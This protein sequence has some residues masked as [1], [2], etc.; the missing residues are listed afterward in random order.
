MT[1]LCACPSRPPIRVQL[2]ARAGAAAVVQMEQATLALPPAAANAS[3]DASAASARI[4]VQLSGTP[5]QRVSVQLAVLVPTADPA[6]AGGSNR[7]YSSGPASVAGWAA[8]DPAQL[9]LEPSTLSWTAMER[10]STKHVTLRSA[11]ELP[12]AL[13][14][15]DALDAANGHPAADRPRGQPLLR[16]ALAAAQGATIARPQNATSLVLDASDADSEEADSGLPLFGF[17]ANQVAYPPSSDG[18]SGDNSSSSVARIPVRLLAGQVREPATVR[19]TVQLLS[20]QGPSQSLQQFLPTRASHGFLYFLPIDFKAAEA[21]GSRAEADGSRA[22]AAA[23]AARQQPVQQVE[24][25]WAELPLA[26]DRIPPEAEYH[27]G[28]CDGCPDVFRVCFSCSSLLGSFH[29]ILPTA[30]NV[31]MFTAPRAGARGCIQRACGA[32][33]WCRGTPYFWHTARHLPARVG[34]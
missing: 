3:E 14:L 27:L 10:P 22:A 8:A 34:A 32:A 31:L 24:A 18:G 15:Q 7:T 1:S 19:F 20:P 28:E 29:S 6:A 21:D 4:G 17:D 30:T 26:W 11:A 13:A 33:A 16:V 5:R 12:L 25:Q 9:W 2:P 23:A